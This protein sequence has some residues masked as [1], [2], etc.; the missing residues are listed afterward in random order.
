MKLY[1]LEIVFFMILGVPACLACLQSLQTCLYTITNPHIINPSLPHRRTRPSLPLF[2][3][4]APKPKPNTGSATAQA[5]PD[6]HKHQGSNADQ[7]KTK[8]TRRKTSEAN[9]ANHHHHHHHQYRE[10]QH[11]HHEHQHLWYENA[12]R[13][14]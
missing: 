13:D 11:Y 5:P 14:G 7:P 12:H 1:L 3:Q 2:R 10:H 6:S 4:M 9:E 8:R